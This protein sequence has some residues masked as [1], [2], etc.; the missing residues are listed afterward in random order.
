[1]TADHRAARPSPPADPQPMPPLI[2]AADP[3]AFPHSV[4]HVRH[5]KVFDQVRAALP[6][7]PERLAAIDAFEQE[8]LHGTLEPPPDDDAGD[9][10]RWERWGA[11]YFGKGL[12][13]TD[14][15]FLWSESYF[16]RRLLSATG[17]FA[18]PW[19]GVDPFGPMKAASLSGPGLAA[20]LAE[21]GSPAAADLAPAERDAAALHASL[22][23]NR[24]DLGFQ[25]VAGAP[26]VPEVLVDDG[27]AF[28]A[29]LEHRPGR[30]NLVADNA[31]EELVYDLLLID[32]LLATGRATEVTLYLKPRPYYVSD[33]TAQDFAA[34]VHLLGAVAGPAA[35]AASRLR[36]HC[37]T[38]RLRLEAPA[39]FCSPLGF[40][41]LPKDLVDAIA[42]ASLTVFKGDLNYRRLVGDRLWPE[43]TPFRTLTSHLPGPVAALR[44]CKSDVAVGMDLDMV[45]A[46]DAAE[47]GWRFGGRHAVI[48]FS[49]R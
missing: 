42:T 29:H 32:R 34:A 4:F 37:A 24:A 15:P 5:P 21:L 41:A 7:G 38:G 31:A 49:G 36:G 39:F 43:D 44:T 14:A 6:Y 26:V 28:W 47:P 19:R 3:A 30:V 17:Y 33:A 23:G 16:H 40:D 13:W 45:G 22:W 2:T 35:D 1:M 27:P 12:L 46:L 9:R 25:L 11:P 20:E 8:S 18:G 10:A 48:Q